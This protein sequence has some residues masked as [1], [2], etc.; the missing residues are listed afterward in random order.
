M[1]K[2]IVALMACALIAGCKKGPTYDCYTCAQT[3]PVP[4]P[5]SA[6]DTTVCAY[7]NDVTYTSTSS[8]TGYYYV[9]NSNTTAHYACT[10]K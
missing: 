4:V 10:K 6:Q 5:P 3:S 8:T 7:S 9:V 1:K 2:I